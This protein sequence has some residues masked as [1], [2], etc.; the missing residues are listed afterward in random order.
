MED[1]IA[2]LDR[3]GPARVLLEIGGE[4]GE[5]RSRVGRAALLQH[6][7]H[8][9]AALEVADGGADLM[10]RGQKLQQTVAADKAGPAGDQYPA[11]IAIPV[12]YD[13]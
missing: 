10:S 4:E 13:T 5:H 3:L 9:V 12:V 8:I 7:Q 11:H 6:G 1:V 2:T